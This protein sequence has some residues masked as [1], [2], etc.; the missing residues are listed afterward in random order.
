MLIDEREISDRIH[1][2]FEMEPIPGGFARLKIELDSRTA[3]RGAAARV[4]S[5]RQWMALVAALVAVAI[6]ASVIGYAIQT[7][8]AP[9]KN[10]PPAPTS[11]QPIV[12]YSFYSA[13]DAAVQLEGDRSL[14]LI[15][16]DGGRTWIH[17]PLNFPQT[18]IRWIDSRHLVAV[19]GSVGRPNQVASSSDGGLTWHVVPVTFP[20]QPGMTFFLNAREGWTL[21]MV[22]STPCFSDPTT[23]RHTLDGGATWQVIS[24]IAGPVG[25]VPLRIYFTDTKHG[26]MSTVSNDTVPRLLMT[27]NGGRTWRTTELPIPATIQVTPVDCGGVNCVVDPVMF[28][29]RGVVTVI[30][31]GPGPYTVTTRDGGMTWTSP[32]VMPFA[33]PSAMPDQWVHPLDPNDWWTV[34]ASGFLYRTLDAG[35][36]WQHIA[37]ALPAGYTLDSVT[38]GESGVLWGVTRTDASGQYPLRSTDGGA[39]WSLVKLPGS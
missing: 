22:S 18:F 3:R 11:V 8:P 7:R 5:P 35:A 9:A 36:T 24:T 21:C 34:D 17:T 27:G 31:L 29:A 23:V 2:A 15:T 13:S 14:V 19:M 32:Q 12:N 16:H 25:V 1:A 26:F 38:P 4:A 10:P 37:A 6:T 39:T 30:G 20:W 33:S 28:G